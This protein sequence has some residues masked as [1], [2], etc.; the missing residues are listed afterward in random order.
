LV[1][2][3]N[4][5]HLEQTNVAAGKMSISEAHHKLRHISHATI[6][7]AISTRQITGIKLDMDL[8]PKFCKA[9]VKVKSSREPFS[10]K[11]ETQATKYGKWVHWDLWD[12]AS[13][14]SLSGNY[15][16]AAHIDN[17]TCEN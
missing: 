2:P 9:C 7:H 3:N 1:N 10:K 15:Y 8:K 11:S 5:N 13:V 4:A 6:K 17:H 12:P 14:K 16:V